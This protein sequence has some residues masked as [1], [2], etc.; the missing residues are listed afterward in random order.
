MFKEVLKNNN[1]ICIIGPCASGKSIALNDLYKNFKED[2]IFIKNKNFN[3]NKNKSIIFLDDDL[4]DLNK[5]QK[6]KFFNHI[7]SN[8][9]KLVYTTTNPE[10]ILY[11]DYLYILDNCKILIN[12]KTLKVLENEKIIKRLGL[13]NPFIIDLSIQLK[14]YNLIDK[15]FKNE[16]E[17]V[18]ALW[19]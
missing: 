19:K 18:E 5:E 17:L 1:I 16:R 11:S 3:L 12:G 2:A 13:K 8:N 7:L 14:H 4:W 10:D 6:D 15:L 9:L